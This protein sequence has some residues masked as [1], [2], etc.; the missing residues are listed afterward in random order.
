VSSQPGKRL[1]PQAYDALVEALATFQWWK[2]EFQRMVEALFAA[3]PTV[4][5]GTGGTGSTKREQ[6]RV[7]A[8]RLREREAKLQSVTLGALIT[9]SE[10]DDRFAHLARSTTAPARSRPPGPRCGRSGE[11]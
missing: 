1:H 10:Y 11:S 5:A 2:P 9:L 6:S 3:A 8:A 4:L 7:I